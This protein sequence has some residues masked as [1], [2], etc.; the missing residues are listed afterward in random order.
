MLVVNES[1]PAAAHMGPRPAEVLQQV[2]IG[3]AGV[4]QGVGEHRQC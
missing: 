1:Q 4:L 3:A 2:S